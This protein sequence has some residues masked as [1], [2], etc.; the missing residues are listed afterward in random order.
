[1]AEGSHYTD[2]QRREAVG[3]YVVLGNWQ[4]VSKATGIPHRTCTSWAHA[5]WFAT[6]FAEVRA[7]KGA[8]LDGA[9]TRI[10][11]KAADEILDRLENGDAVLIDGEVKRR[12][13]SARD[14][15]M[16]NGIIYD[17]RALA[18]NEPTGITG[19]IQEGYLPGLAAYL[20]DLARK[21]ALAEGRPPDDDNFDAKY[22]GPV[23]PP[24]RGKS[25]R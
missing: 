17:K 3:H 24:D 10:I 18:R 9:F 13:V 11:H 19:K 4:A 23:S 6:L 22:V 5:P 1:M 21:K 15:A 25:S 7:E 12:P 8:E 14:L 16:I 20:T 2:E